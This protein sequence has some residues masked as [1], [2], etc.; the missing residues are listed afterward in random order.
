M[1]VFGKKKKALLYFKD[2]IE[3]KIT[4]E[5][6]LNE[7]KNN[8]Y[9]EKIISKVAI[10]KRRLFIN[11]ENLLK[12]SINLERLCLCVQDSI[13]MTLDY[14]KIKYVINQKEYLIFEKWSNILP[15]C[16]YGKF[17]DIY[18]SL[19]EIDLK[20]KHTDEWYVNYIRSIYK[21][22]KDLP[23]WLQSFEWPKNEDGTPC[24]F[25][26]QTGD[27]DIDDYIEYYFRNN[28]NEIIKIEQYI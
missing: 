28:K 10:K 12:L 8:K 6:F 25:L 9:Y 5:S 7:Y 18:I 20:E 17:E 13:V 22:E 24:L 27:P 3:S 11:Y 4:N 26:Y 1:I 23:N 2:Y 14:Y 15:A 16:F 21:S 19:E